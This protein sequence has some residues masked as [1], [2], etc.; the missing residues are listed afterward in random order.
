MHMPLTPD[1]NLSRQI[2]RLTLRFNVLD[3]LFGLDIAHAMDT[4]NTVTA[5]D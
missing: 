1:A 5:I 4:G 2:L 3:Q